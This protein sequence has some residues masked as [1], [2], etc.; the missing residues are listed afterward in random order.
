MSSKTF[1]L[2]FFLGESEAPLIGNDTGKLFSSLTDRARGSGEL[3]RSSSLI[4]RDGEPA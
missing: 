1:V 2:R 4:R 3:E